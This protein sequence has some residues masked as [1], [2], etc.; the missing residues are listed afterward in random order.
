MFK[1]AFDLLFSLTGLV[2]LLPVFSIISVFIIIG[3]KGPVFYKQIRVGRNNVNFGLL[4]FR[5]MCTGADS[6]GLLTVGDN[7]PRVTT[8]GFWLR[9][10]K[11]D[12]LPQLI[13]ILIGDMSF[14]GPRPEVR[15]YVELYDTGQQRVLSV[16][17]GITDWAS[18][19]F[20]NEN[21]LL[22][23]ADDPEGFYIKNIIPLK[24]NR[25][26]EYIDHHSLWIDLKIIILTLKKIILN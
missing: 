15:K 5:T 12:E 21:Q 4:K 1:R 16:K 26:L 7:D 23:S 3:S 13:N 17:P 20:C 18:I 25:N 19:Q 14:V 6:L 2:F 11:I 8:V 9:K 22:A 24:I 10:Y